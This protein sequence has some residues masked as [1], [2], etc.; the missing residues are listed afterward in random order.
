L[1]FILEELEISFA[2]NKTADVIS[3]ENIF[4]YY[5]HKCE[6]IS[7]TLPQDASTK[8]TV[9]SYLSLEIHIMCIYYIVYTAGALSMICTDF[10]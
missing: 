8:F 1:S 10:M 7:L 2:P 4:F 9:F 6:A 3:A 5:L